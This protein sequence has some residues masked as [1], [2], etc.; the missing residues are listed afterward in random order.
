MTRKY[1]HR[2]LPADQS[3]RI[4]KGGC[5]RQV[6]IIETTK[7]VLA[8]GAL[9]RRVSG[10]HAVHE[11]DDSGKQATVFQQKFYRLRE[12]LEFRCARARRE[13]A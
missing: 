5:G 3:C 11:G 4:S 1:N 10:Y 9:R 12:T 8:F 2:V 7:D 13:V 6:V